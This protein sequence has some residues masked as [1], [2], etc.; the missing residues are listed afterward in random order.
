MDE[1][2]RMR[3]LNAS[4]LKFS[5]DIDNLMYLSRSIDS[6]RFQQDSS[7]SPF[8]QVETRRIQ[9]GFP[10]PKSGPGGPGAVRVKPFRS[11]HLFFNAIQNL[12][13]VVRVV[14]VKSNIYTRARVRGNFIF[15]IYYNFFF[16]LKNTRTTRTKE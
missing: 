10:R 9:K 15:H 7:L 14:R 12:T 16:I 6:M 8:P 11:G 2:R 3:G 5:H 4:I 1:E 13:R